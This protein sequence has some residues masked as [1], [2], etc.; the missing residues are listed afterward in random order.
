MSFERAPEVLWTP[1]EA[2]GTRPRRH[3]GRVEIQVVLAAWRG[4]PAVLLV[5]EMPSE[6]CHIAGMTDHAPPPYDLIIRHC[7]IHAERYRWDIRRGGMPVQSSMDSFASEQE[8]HADGRREVERL[9][10]Q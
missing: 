6:Q 1:P 8:A 5:V 2:V 7:T 4:P 10:S 3:P 9:T